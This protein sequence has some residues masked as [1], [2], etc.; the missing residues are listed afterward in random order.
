MLDERFRAAG[1]GKHNIMCLLAEGSKTVT[2]W[3][4]KTGIVFAA[5]LQSEESHTRQHSALEHSDNMQ[6]SATL[7]HYGQGL[8]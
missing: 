5:A 2:T 7:L 3:Q 1:H 4:A 6:C 8:S